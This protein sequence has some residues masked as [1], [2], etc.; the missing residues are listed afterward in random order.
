MPITKQL[1]QQ[2]QHIQQQY[3]CASQDLWIQHLTTLEAF[4]L[5]KFLEEQ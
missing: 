5:D 3:V 4:I 1:E 2:I